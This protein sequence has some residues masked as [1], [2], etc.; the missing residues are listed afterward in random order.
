MKLENQLYFYG[1][2][3]PVARQSKLVGKWVISFMIRT[4]I[5]P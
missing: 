2:I 4:D 3:V 1:S 5:F